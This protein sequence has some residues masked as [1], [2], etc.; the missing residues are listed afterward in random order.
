MISEI[1][2]NTFVSMFEANLRGKDF[3]SSDEH[4]MRLAL[5]E[6]EFAAGKGEVPVGAVI[7]APDG[8]TVIAQGHNQPITTH[9]PTAHAEIV[10]IRAAAQALQ[11]YR[12]DGCSLHA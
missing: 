3:S 11:N 7:V 10:A 6:A 9:D 1:S 12:L 8:E 5:A 4:F 2:R